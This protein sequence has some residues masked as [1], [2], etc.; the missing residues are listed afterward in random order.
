LSEC[1]L[2]LDF[3]DCTLKIHENRFQDFISEIRTQSVAEGATVIIAQS[4]IESIHAENQAIENFLNN[5]IQVLESKLNL[6]ETVKKRIETYQAENSIL[7]DQLKEAMK[8]AAENKS[9]AR[10]IFEKLWSD[11]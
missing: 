8:A 10:G 9:V 3:S 1:I 4:D 2:I 5:R 11:T 6:I 7:K